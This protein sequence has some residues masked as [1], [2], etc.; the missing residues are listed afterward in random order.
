MAAIS[1]QL[2]NRPKSTQLKRWCG[3]WCCYFI[4]QLALIC[5]IACIIDELNP[6]NL[7]YVES[8]PK[9]AIFVCR[10]DQPSAAKPDSA[11]TFSNAPYRHQLVA[12]FAMVVVGL[13]LLLQSTIPV[14]GLAYQRLHLASCDLLPT[15][16]PPRAA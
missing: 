15:L 9:L 2:S 8:N 10:I 12:L 14:L 5:P 16:P 3:F 6:I 11:Q 4:L 7:S 13:A 1:Q